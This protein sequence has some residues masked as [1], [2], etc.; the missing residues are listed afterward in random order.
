ML[1]GPP[2]MAQVQ[3]LSWFS[4]TSECAA[5][6]PYLR[7]GP[8]AAA[9]ARPCTEDKAD[10]TK[11]EVTIPV[12]HVPQDAASTKQQDAHLHMSTCLN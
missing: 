8:L 4:R 6:G 9:L 2:T 3:L 11:A 10:T 12:P 1:V 5:V 7:V